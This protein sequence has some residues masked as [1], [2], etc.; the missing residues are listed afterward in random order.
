MGFLLDEH[1]G[2]RLPHLNWADNIFL[3]AEDVGT[4]QKMTQET[5]FAMYEAGLEWKKSSLQTMSAGSLRA[6][7]VKVSIPSRSSDTWEYTQV[8]ELEALGNLLDQT[9]S[10]T[11]SVEP[12]PQKAESSFWR[13]HR[14]LRGPGPV[15]AKLCAWTGVQQAVAAFGSRNWHIS[16]ALLHQLKAWEYKFLR[17]VF[18]MRRKSV[19]GNLEGRIQYNKRTSMQLAQWLSACKVK[20]LHLKVLTSTY[21]SAWDEQISPFPS[22]INY[23]QLAR[24]RRSRLWWE[25]IKD[26]DV[27][28]R[29]RL[30]LTRT[31][32]GPQANWENILAEQLGLDW[33]HQLENLTFRTE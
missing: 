29:R 21:K 15:K 32:R 25:G 23:L 27:N 14:L 22:G 31:R 16:S 19:D 30:G 20:P 26:E 9:G 10:T 18:N 4:M 5:T 3:L 12:R 17:K 6:A 33:R 24:C 13:Y 1:Q 11:A 8:T 2:I 7:E 28:K